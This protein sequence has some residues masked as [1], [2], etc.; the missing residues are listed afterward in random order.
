MGKKKKGPR[1]D[2]VRGLT[3]TRAL[4]PD[5]FRGTMFYDFNGSFTCTASTLVSTVFRANSVHDPDFSGAG[6]TCAGYTTAS[7]VY[8]RFRVVGLKAIITVHNT[9]AG[10]TNLVIVANN[11][12]TIGTSVT[13]TLA[14]RHVYT[15][16]IGP[17]TGNGIHK[18]QVSFPIYKIWGGTQREILSEDDFTG[19]TAS[20]V[21]NNQ[22]F[23]HVGFSTPGTATTATVNVRI[24]YDV[25]WDIPI[26]MP[27]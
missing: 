13:E 25:I 3:I 26:S 14:Q 6:T 19:T 11:L 4:F 17:L 10:S 16:P 24:E 8:L 1:R 2:V 7:A 22:L 20:P 23:L 18:H 15:A 21:P 27:Y 5:R 12:N 9:G